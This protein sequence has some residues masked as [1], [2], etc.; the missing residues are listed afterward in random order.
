[1]GSTLCV[2]DPQEIPSV[3]PC[4]PDPEEDLYLGCTFAMGKYFGSPLSLALGSFYFLSSENTC[5]G[6]WIQKRIHQGGAC[7]MGTE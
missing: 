3:G 2:P 6:L 5:G 1:M 7:H 4:S